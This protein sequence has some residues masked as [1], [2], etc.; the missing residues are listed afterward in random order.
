ML[1]IVLEADTGW[2]TSKDVGPPKRW[3]VRSMS[4]GEGNKTFLIRVW[5]PLSS[6]HVLKTL[7]GSPKGKAQRG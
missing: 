3:I 7:S 6:K 4:V 2:C 1:Q 5:K